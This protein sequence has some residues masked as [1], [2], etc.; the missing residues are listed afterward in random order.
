MT[1]PLCFL[2]AISMLYTQRQYNYELQYRQYEQAHY[3]F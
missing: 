1:K 2:L 3:N